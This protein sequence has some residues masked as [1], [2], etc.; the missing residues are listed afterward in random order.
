MALTCRLGW[1]SGERLGWAIEAQRGSGA[2]S[3][4]ASTCGLEATGSPRSAS[5]CIRRR[6]AGSMMTAALRLVRDY[7]FDVAG[8]QVLRWRAVVG[9]WGSRRV[10]A[11]VRLPVRRH[12]PPA[13]GA[14]R[15]VARRLAGHHDPRRSP[16]A[17]GWLDPPVL[18]GAAS[19]CDPFASAI[20]AASSR[21]AGRTYAALAGLAAAAVHVGRRPGLSRRQPPRWLRAGNGLA[22]CIADPRRTTVPG[23]ISLEGYANY[24]RR[25]EI[26]YWAHPDARGRG[27]VSEAVRLVTGR[28][29]GP[30]LADSLPDP[31]RRRQPRSRRRRRAGGISGSGSSPAA[32]PLG[33]GA[34]DDLVLYSGP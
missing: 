33:D 17:A 23:S 14:S 22:W 13:A 15:R 34:V 27:V 20:S 3:A 21:P 1:A 6:A 32:E 10:A 12:G 2:A 4:A 28:A 19:Y 7:G 8:L 29:T 5:G 26:G 11:K 24:A 25:G 9:N 31:L 16:R 18:S 30:G